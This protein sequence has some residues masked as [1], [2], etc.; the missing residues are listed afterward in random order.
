MEIK[1]LITLKIIILTSREEKIRLGKE[2][3]YIERLHLALLP[4][5]LDCIS[6]YL[7]CNCAKD[8]EGLLHLVPKC[9]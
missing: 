4:I 9:S 1:S 3:T 6:Q 7:A 2:N 5:D 8:H